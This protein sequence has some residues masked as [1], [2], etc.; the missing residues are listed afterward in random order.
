MPELPDVEGFRRELARH[1]EGRR[2]VRVDVPDAELARN[3]SATALS[4]ALAGSRFAEPRRHGKWLIAPAGDAEVLMHFGMT[5][6][7][8]WTEDAARHRHDRL[9]FVCEDGELR[10]NNMRRFGGVWLAEDADERGRVT[11]PLGPDAASLTRER[12]EDLLAGRRG[13]IKAALMDQRL[14]AGVGNLLSDEIVWRARVHPATPVGALGRARRGRLYDG[15]APRSANRRATGACRTASVGSR[16]CVT[17]ATPRV[18]A[19]VR[20]FSARR[21]A[22]GR[23]AG[24]RAVSGGKATTGIEP[25]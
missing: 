19:A 11:G 7:L 9:V 22:A 20:G 18:R 25:V 16:P 6:L 1:A 2:I 5:G 8:R 17:T 23:R 14:I 24:V 4:D 21:S 10:Y 13:S 3:R 12:F 15:Y